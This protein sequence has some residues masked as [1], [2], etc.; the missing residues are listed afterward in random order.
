MFVNELSDACPVM[1]RKNPVYAIIFATLLNDGNAM[2]PHLIKVG[3]KINTAEYLKFLNV[4]L[5]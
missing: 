3:F 2:P 4:L 1:Q 5:S